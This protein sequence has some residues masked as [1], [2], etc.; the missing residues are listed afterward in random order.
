MITSVTHV[1]EHHFFFVVGLST[2][3]ASLTLHTLPWVGLNH[4]NKLHGHV[5]ARRV[6]AVATLGAVYKWL[7]LPSLAGL[8][9]LQTNP[10][11]SIW[12]DLWLEG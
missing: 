11:Q 12:N 9:T 3:N 4:G 7:S 6:A 1:T 8:L 5:Q 10:T 2:Y